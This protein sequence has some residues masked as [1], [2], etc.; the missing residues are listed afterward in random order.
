MCLESRVSSH[1][2]L[3]IFRTLIA[4]F[5]VWAID[6]V[7]KVLLFFE[8]ASAEITELGLA[9]TIVVTPNIEH[10]REGM[11]LRNR[12]TSAYLNRSHTMS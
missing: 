2:P 1:V 11:S 10:S 4:S 5:P 3:L 6:E 9:S 8:L 12:G 7:A